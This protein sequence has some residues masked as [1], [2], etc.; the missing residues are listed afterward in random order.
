MWDATVAVRLV[1][2]FIG[3]LLVLVA[4]EFWLTAKGF[5]SVGNHVWD[6]LDLHP[7]LNIGLALFLGALIGHFFAKGP[8]PWH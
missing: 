1:D 7:W 6:Y 5:K 8:F 3:L 4:L 2:T